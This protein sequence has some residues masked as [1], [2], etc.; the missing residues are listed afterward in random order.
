MSKHL[1]VKKLIYSKYLC[2]C[3]LYHDSEVDIM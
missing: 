3:A 2:V 1:V